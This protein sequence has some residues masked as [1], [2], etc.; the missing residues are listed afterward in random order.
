MSTSSTTVLYEPPWR[1]FQIAFSST[2]AAQSRCAIAS[3]APSSS[4]FVHIVR[5][6]GPSVIKEATVPVIFPQ[7]HIQFSPLGSASNGTLMISTADCLRLWQVTTDSVSLATSIPNDGPCEILTCADWSPLDNMV[8]AG[9]TEGA[10]SMFDV[11][12]LCP[13]SRI[14]AHDHQV[15]DVKFIT[16]SPTFVTAG[17]E[18]SIRFFDLRDLMSSFVYFQTAMPLLRLAVSPISTTKVATFSKDSRTVSIIDTRS[19][20][21]ACNKVHHTAKVTSIDWSSLVEDRLFST[22]VAGNLMMS[23]LAEGVLDGESSLLYHAPGAIQNSAI[24][25]T[26]VALVTD[27]AVELV[28]G[29]H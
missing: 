16:A 2:F 18:G 25:L 4:N 20:G 10:V 28:N 29:P 7:T 8:I 14:V 11:T 3:F 13:L 5:L 22:D 21:M 26:G 19:P 17:L 1:P 6:V 23:D 27:T 15:H 24:A 9:T 12:T